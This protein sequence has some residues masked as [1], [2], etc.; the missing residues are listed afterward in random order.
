MALFG[1]SEN[2]SSLIKKIQSDAQMSPEN[3]SEILEQL[4][5]SPEFL[6][7]K[8]LWMVSHSKG[9]VRQFAHKRIA[10]LQD[11]KI[12]DSLLRELPG[13]SENIRKEMASLIHRLD[14]KR[15]SVHLSKMVHSKK[16]E[17]REAALD[18]IH[19]SPNWEDYLGF[20]KVTFRDP[21]SKIA[22]RTTRIL[23]SNIDNET[24]FLMLRARISDDDPKIRRIIIE[25]FAKRP[26]PEIV[27]PFFERIALEDHEC[28][29]L[30]V[31][32]LSR[33]AKKS[34]NAIEERLLPMLADEEPEIREIAVKL[35]KEMPDRQRVLKIFLN[36]LTGVASWVRER[37]LESMQKISSDLTEALPPLLLDEDQGIRV[38]AMIMATGSNDEGLIPPLLKIFNSQ[39]DWWI[40]SMAADLL[41]T[42]PH[43]E[44]TQELIKKID[45]PDLSY[46]AI[47]ALGQQ[48]SPRG[49]DALKTK[50]TDSNPGIRRAVLKAMSD[51]PSEEAQEIIVQTARADSDIEVKDFAIELL[52]AKNEGN[53]A[54]LAE[55]ER[56]SRKELEDRAMEF[57]KGGLSLQMENETLN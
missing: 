14:G 21:D 26:R 33:L 13:K 18:L 31:T 57:A 56:K 1:K 54:L 34:Q 10:A 39:E 30:M 29:G 28:R 32:A 37:S 20:L 48:G 4:G 19:Q 53:E 12:A 50:L 5:A 42:F 47:S 45:D 51:H 46:S 11:P 22:Q 16:I 25:A 8:N 35:L 52:R 40:R 27:E 9:A 43:P 49:L 23:S 41:K 24:C 38:G 6:P 2:I 55:L 3:L 36:H 17:I 7:S 15:V 44:I